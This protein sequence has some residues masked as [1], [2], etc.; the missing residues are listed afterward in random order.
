MG[1]A[2]SR[3]GHWRPRRRRRHRRR[4]I[5]VTAGGRCCRR[6]MWSATASGTAFGSDCGSGIDSRNGCASGIAIWIVSG[7][8]NLLGSATR[9]DG[10]GGRGSEESGLLIGRRR[11]DLGS[12]ARRHSELRLHRRRYRSLLN[13]PDGSGLRLVAGLRPAGRCP[14]VLPTHRGTTRRPR[15]RVCV[16]SE[17]VGQDPSRSRLLVH[18]LT[19]ILVL[20]TQADHQPCCGTETCNSSGGWR[21]KEV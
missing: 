15:G 9:T 1:V 2:S 14:V 3:L 10:C 16:S 17:A 19:A 8:R 12:A 6:P 18:L 20:G 7:S 13:T 21:R 5:R 11:R 4:G